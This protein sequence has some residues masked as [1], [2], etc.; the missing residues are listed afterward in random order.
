MQILQKFYINSVLGN[1]ALQILVSSKSPRTNPLWIPRMAM[2]FLHFLKLSRDISL[3]FREVEKCTKEKK[4]NLL[5]LC[6]HIWTIK[7]GDAV[8]EI[9]TYATLQNNCQNSE[10][11]HMLYLFLSI[12]RLA[13]VYQVLVTLW[14]TLC[15]EW[16]ELAQYRFLEEF[17]RGMVFSFSVLL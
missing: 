8:I 6:N 7:E 3:K 1:W 16:L 4:K 2:H 13:S 15:D 10:D 5:H 17:S 12:L 9:L 11:T 14:I